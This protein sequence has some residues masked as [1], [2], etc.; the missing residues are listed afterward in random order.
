LLDDKRITLKDLAVIIPVSKEET[1]LEKLQDDLNQVARGISIV[2]VRGSKRFQQLNDGVHQTKKPY[3]WFLHADT[4]VTKENVSALLSSLNKE[5][6]ALH[7]FR[8]KFHRDGPPTMLM[9]EWGCWIRSRL[10]KV[11]F[12]D[13]G[14]CLSRRNFEKIGAY[15]TN[16]S[17]GEDHIFIWKARQAGIDLRYIHEA[18]STSARKYNE[19]GWLRLTMRY[20]YLWSR[21]ALPE[22]SKLVKLRIGKGRGNLP[23]QLRRSP[24]HP[25]GSS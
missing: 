24:R 3:L 1:E 23:S 13:Q 10:M 20:A 4:R 9:N 14:F 25:P 19:V 7:Y 6:D 8:L 22:W 17:F 21:Q 18:L 15:P 2:I 16:L 11:P 5:S 12:G